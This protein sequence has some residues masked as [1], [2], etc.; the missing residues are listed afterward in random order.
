[1]RYGFIGLGELGGALASSLLRRG[2][3]LRVHDIDASRVQRL[4]AAG[5]IAAKSPRALAEESDAAITCL[6]SPTVSE[7]VLSGP[8]GVLAGLKGRGAWIEMSTLGPEEIR[9]L[10][11]LAAGQGVRTLEAP[12]TGGVHLAARGEV[13]VLVGG[14]ADLYETHRPALEAMGKRLFFMGP[15]GSAA[16]IKVITNM[17]AFIH[18]VADG[19][20]LMLA[21]RGGLD[22]A[23][24]WKAIA[25]SSGTSFVHETEGQLILNGSYDIGFTMDL[26]LKDLGF[27]AKAGAELG[28]PLELATRTLET[29]RRGKAA[30][31]GAAQSTQI[32]K[33]LEDALGTDLRAEGFPARL[34]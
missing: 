26:A 24:A 2:F 9:R 3:A 22:L 19:E 11:D 13:T 15:L 27:A 29:F 14:D 16:L 30:F 25:A 6:P 12:V 10:A 32:V 18:L 20:A 31:G 34:T 28:V 8:D 4:V 33:L 7:R 21:R 17:L 23:Q 5:A 1:M